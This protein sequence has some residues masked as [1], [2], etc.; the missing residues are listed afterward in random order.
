M[1]SLQSGSLEPDC[2]QA[3]ASL[4]PELKGR[5]DHVVP[6]FQVRGWREAEPKQGQLY[7]CSVDKPLSVPR[8]PSGYGRY[9]NFNLSLIFFFS[10]SFPLPFYLC[11][12]V[13]DKFTYR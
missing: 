13:L 7:L 12:S 4:R 8:D 5:V 3:T 9:S 2:V 1:P 11:F 10:S 6:W